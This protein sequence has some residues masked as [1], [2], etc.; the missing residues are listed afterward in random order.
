[1]SFDRIDVLMLQDR[2]TEVHIS[3]ALL[4]YVQDLLDFTRS[5]IHYRMSQTRHS[6]FDRLVSEIL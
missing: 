5:S 1:M 6:S 2:V 3:D 4:E